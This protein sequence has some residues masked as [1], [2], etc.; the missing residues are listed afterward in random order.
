VDDPTAR[1]RGKLPSMS[2]ISELAALREQIEQQERRIVELEV[3]AAFRRKAADDLDEV[4]RE[5]GQRLVLLERRLAELL[6]QLAAATH[7]GEV[8]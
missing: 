2:D 1:E 7:E 5:Q 8:D 4:V 6:G 3:E